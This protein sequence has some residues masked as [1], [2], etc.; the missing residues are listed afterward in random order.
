MTARGASS[1]AGQKPALGHQ[2][3][4]GRCPP[5]AARMGC[6]AEDHGPFGLMG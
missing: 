2:I 1:Q 5:P 6:A 4:A 3:G